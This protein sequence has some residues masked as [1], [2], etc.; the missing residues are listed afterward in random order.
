MTLT[1]N[2]AFLNFA[3]V[4]KR[5]RA[6]EVQSISPHAALKRHLCPFPQINNNKRSKEC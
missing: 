1:M 6:M 3:D 4:P 2:R 5:L